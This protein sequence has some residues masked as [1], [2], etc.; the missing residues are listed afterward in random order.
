MTSGWKVLPIASP[1]PNSQTLLY[2]YDIG[3]TN[4]T[5]YVTDLTKLWVEDRDRK[6]II[7]KAW[8]ADASIDPSE[9]IDQLQLLLNKLQ[10]S[11]EGTEKTS[12]DL[13]AEINFDH[14]IDLKATIPLPSSLRPLEWI[15]NLKL[16]SA[17]EF[18]AK[19]V[20]PC[21]EHLLYSRYQ[22]S[23]L[24]GCL[25][26][27]DHVIGKLVDKI[28]SIGIDMNA[29]FPNAPIHKGPKQFSRDFVGGSVKGLSD[30]NEEEWLNSLD[31]LFKPNLKKDDFLSCNTSLKAS[32]DLYNQI[33]NKSRPK[34]GNLQSQ[35]SEPL[36][37]KVCI[38]NLGR[39]AARVANSSCNSKPILLE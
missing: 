21:F 1:G 34:R 6:Q 38:H 33:F 26:A 24:I 12:L 14:N 22:A 9:G 20:E 25:K 30:F 2:K 37:P 5:I 36:T 17:T 15:F 16:A 39:S 32:L 11:L 29:V 4:Y 19:F 7:K 31:P 10:T 18:S 13:Q 8:D 35:S 28:Q 27:K 3:A 23:S